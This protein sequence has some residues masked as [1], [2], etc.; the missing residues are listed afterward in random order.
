MYLKTMAYR[1]HLAI[2][3]VTVAGCA[4]P[5]RE[6]SRV[7]YG[8]TGR[9]FRTS[10]VK[11]CVGLSALRINPEKEMTSQEV[12]DVR[13]RL[14]ESQH[15]PYSHPQIFTIAHVRTLLEWTN[16]QGAGVVVKAEDVEELAP[17][18]AQAFS[19]AKDDEQVWFIAKRH[20][21]G[22]EKTGIILRGIFA[23]RHGS[24]SG[25]PPSSTVAQLHLEAT[26]VVIYIFCT[27][28]N[29]L[30]DPSHEMRCP[31]SLLLRGEPGSVVDPSEK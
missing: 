3:V 19:E 25:R 24:S 12:A 29:K 7:I 28:E 18:I 26:D 21:S 11:A 10:D 27:S 14:R 8:E 20:L 9:T 4:S 31:L 1:V 13:L 2:F 23:S 30:F 17:Y 5:W 15:T 22:G 16:S 6:E